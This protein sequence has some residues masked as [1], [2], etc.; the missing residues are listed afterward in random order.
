[1]GMGS[2]VDGHTIDGDEKIGAVV[3]VESAEEILSGFASSG[4]LGD[5]DAGD[6]FEDFAPAERGPGEEVGAAGNPEGC[7]GGLFEEI[8]RFPY[9]HDFIETHWAFG[10]FDFGD[11]SGEGG[12]L[13]RVCEEL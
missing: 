4:V 10:E 12:V 8:R 6:G 9:D 13:C 5:D 1:M 2:H 11:W 3:E 7:G